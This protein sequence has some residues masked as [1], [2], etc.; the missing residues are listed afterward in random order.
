LT[1]LVGGGNICDLS[2]LQI[3]DL[4]SNYFVSL[5][6]DIGQLRNLQVSTYSSVTCVSTCADFG[7]EC[8]LK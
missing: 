5:P 4:H 1:S 2:M 8:V 3:L 7:R 6:D